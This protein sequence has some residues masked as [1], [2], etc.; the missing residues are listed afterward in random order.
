[1]CKNKIIIVNKLKI[2]RDVEGEWEKR[3][4]EEEGKWVEKQEELNT[5]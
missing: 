5:H 2:R 1:M 3:R 4:N